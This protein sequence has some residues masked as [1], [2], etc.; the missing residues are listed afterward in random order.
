MPCL[1]RRR[2]A[3]RRS[4]R[5]CCNALIEH[6]SGIVEQLRLSVV[7]TNVAAIRL[8]QKH[9]FE[10]YGQELRALKRALGYSDEI[11]MARRLTE[12]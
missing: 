5:R 10:I 11:L 8:Y 1:S 7:D 3:S 4:A 9:G 2:R 6:A 12:R